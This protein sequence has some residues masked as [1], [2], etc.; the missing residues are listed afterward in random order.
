MRKEGKKGNMFTV[1][2]RG[3]NPFTNRASLAN[4]RL[5][6]RYLRVT[7][8]AFQTVAAICAPSL[9]SSVSTKTARRDK[10]DG[11]TSSVFV[12]PPF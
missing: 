11:P 7:V 1:L 12:L 4:R 3:L 5:R 9:M 6:P 8:Y 10:T 2:A